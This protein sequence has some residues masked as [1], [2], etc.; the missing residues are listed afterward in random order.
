MG[1]QQLLSR[2]RKGQVWLVDA[3][4]KLEEMSDMGVGSQLEAQFNLAFRSWISMEAMQ[5]FVT[6]E[7]GCA[8]GFACD[9]RAPVLCE[10]CAR[11]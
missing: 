8:V 10:V 6:G 9:T 5:R 11:G 7:S 3:K 1:N 2:L 4:K